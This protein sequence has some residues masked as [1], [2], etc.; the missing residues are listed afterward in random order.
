MTRFGRDDGAGD[1]TRFE[2]YDDTTLT[3]T[4]GDLSRFIDPAGLTREFLE[5][6]A[7]GLAMKL[8]EVGGQVIE[9]SYDV[10]ASRLT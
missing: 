7:S 6:T 9:L 8:K 10:S 4:R 1:T 2:Y 5:Y 3:H